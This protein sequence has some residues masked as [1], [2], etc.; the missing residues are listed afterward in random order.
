MAVYVTRRPHQFCFS[1]NEIQYSFFVT[2]PTEAGCELQVRLYAADVTGA[3]TDIIN[4]YT[5]APNADGSV[6]LFIQDIIDSLLSFTPP[7]YAINTIQYG[8]DHVKKFGI[9]YRRVTDATP[10]PAWIEDDLA[11]LY[12]FAV[13][14]GIERTKWDWNNYFL[15]AA[16]TY[17]FLTWQPNNRFVSATDDFFISYLHTGNFAEA[18]YRK[19]MVHYTDGTQ[20]SPASEILHGNGE[21]RLYHIPAGIVQLGL[22]LIDPTKQ[23]HYYS[24]ALMSGSDIITFAA[25]YNFYV[26]YRLFYDTKTFQYYNSLGGMEHARILGDTETSSNRNYSEGEMYT[27][28]IVIGDALDPQYMQNNITRLNTFKSDAGYRHTK[29]EMLCLQELYASQFLFECIYS[30]ILRLFILNKGEKINR[31]SDKVFPFAIEWRYGHTETVYTPETDL[32]AGADAESYDAIVCPVPSALAFTKTA[33]A[34]GFKD[35]HF[36]WANIG[37]VD[38][39]MEWKYDYQS[40]Y[41]LIAGPYV[42]ASADLENIADASI[43]NWRVKTICAEGSESAYVNGTNIT[44]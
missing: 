18:I 4:T 21:D 38:Y 9:E 28:N 24:I 11:T 26:D 34:A 35:L 5:L 2:Y 41:T 13:K 42:T 30:K 37:A 15:N 19:I 32:G 12:R 3:L 16:T 14:G 43:I 22:H 39:A 40:T 31:N 6:N 20:A 29:A 10:D 17:P 36:S 25:A 8:F 44:V 33:A 1:K 7:D 27:G 23:I